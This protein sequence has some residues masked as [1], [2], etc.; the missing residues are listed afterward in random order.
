MHMSTQVIPATILLLTSFYYAPGQSLKEHLQK[1]DRFYERKDFDDA[2]VHYMEALAVDP[3]DP[4]TNYRAG[5]SA[6]NKDAYSQAVEYLEKAY[7]LKPDVEAD[8]DYYL[9]MAYQRDHQFSKARLHFENI[10]KTSK[11]LAPLAKEKIRQCID[12]DSLMKIAVNGTVEAL[13]AEI[14]SVFSES[15]PLVTADQNTLVFT[16]DR[17]ADPYQIKSRTN[18]EN[19]YIS[20]RTSGAWSPAAL[21]G[22]PV[23]V[24]Y[25]EAATF[26]SADGKTLL[27]RY[28][29]GG[30]DIY[31]STF[32]DGKWSRPEALNRFVNHP[33]YK[34]SSACLSP[35]GKRLFF[36]SNRPGGKGGFDLYV[37][38]LDA[39]GQW[40]RPSNL[41]STVNTRGDEQGPFMHADNATV[42]FSSNGWATLGDADIFKAK[43]RDGKWSRP[44]NLGYPVNTSAYEGH[45]SLSPD[46]RK[47]Y[48]TSTRSGNDA[49]S[50]IFSV[51]FSLA[52]RPDEALMADSRK[53]APPPISDRE[54]VTLLKGT[55]IDAA[56]TAPLQATVRLVDNVNKKTLSTVTTDHAGNFQIVISHGGNYGLTTERTGYL[57]NSMNFDVP[58]FDKFQQI[59]THVLMVKA[60]VGSKVVLKNIFFDVNESR[61][62][63][64][65]LS[66][67]ES[68]RDI[69]ARNPQ[70]RIQVNGHT[71]NAGD[72][73][74]NLAL[75][76]KRAQSVV[77]YLIKQGISGDRLQAKGYGSERPLVSND[78]EKEGRQMN[79]RT[80]IE[81]VE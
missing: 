7:R 71:D 25:N 51:S 14:N 27:L 42:Y 56:S 43:E 13:G 44:E 12:G 69:L 79:R 48:F 30:G 80:E 28:E 19:V 49:G 32:A 34:E 17:T 53:A 76:L 54:A 67:L 31:I 45:F 29:E 38:T 10:T 18:D 70:W 40:G 63:P 3:D 66:E 75:S 15:T 52:E 5:I 37:S 20:R 77:D 21:I 64:E 72:A 23:N 8:I 50:D 78:D 68:L 57:F 47:G 22:N 35:D 73:Q 60:Q 55:V 41:G 39:N 26:L 4:R 24:K 61:L 62:R 16:S 33:Q 6:F 81:I 9:G 74:R 2:L 1:G 46:S 65:S 58:P 59:D 36:S 11:R